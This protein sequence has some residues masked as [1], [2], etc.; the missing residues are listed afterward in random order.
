MM[1]CIR[2]LHAINDVIHVQTFRSQKVD[3]NVSLQKEFKKVRQSPSC[4]S[5]NV[6]CIAFCL[7]CLK[8]GL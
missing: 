8:Q 6:I 5:K 2:I 4:V 1:K 3:L 7:R